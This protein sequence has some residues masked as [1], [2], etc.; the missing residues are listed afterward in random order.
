MEKDPNPIE[1]I[2]VV[3]NSSPNK[4][5]NGLI[6]IN[7]L[8]KDFRMIFRKITRKVDPLEFKWNKNRQKK[9]KVHSR[10]KF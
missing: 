3:F 10:L 5:D 1:I 7:H 6:P 2:K 9:E 8:I 4:I